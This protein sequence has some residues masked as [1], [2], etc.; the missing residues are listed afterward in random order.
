VNIDLQLAPAILEDSFEYYPDF[1]TAF[2]NWTLLDQDN[3]GTYGFTDVD[4]PG[5]GSP[6][7][8]LIFNPSQ[9]VP[10]LTDV[11]PYEGN[12][13]AACFAALTF[14]NRDWLITERITLG[15]NS[16]LRFQA[17]S[18][19][20][21][22]GLEHFKV[23]VSTMPIAIIQGFQFISGPSEIEAPA[24]WTEY[25]YDLCA[26]DELDVFIAIRCSSYDAF[27]FYVDNFAVHSQGVVPQQDPFGNPVLM[28]TSMSVVA[29]VTINMHQASAGDVLAAFVNVNGIPELRG[30]QTVQDVDGIAGC[31]LQV[32]TETNGE[33]LRF[34]VWDSSTN[35]VLNSPTT[36]NTEVNGT[37]GEWPNSFFVIY[38]S[39][40]V[41]QSIPLLSGW[42]LVSLNVSPSDH[43]LPT[44]LAPISSQIQQ[45]KGTEGI[46][47]PGNPYSTLSALTDGKAY[48]IQVNSN[49][50]CSITGTQIPFDTTLALSE[51]WNLTAYLP[52]N[53]M[54]VATAMQSISNWLQ[55]VKG[56][57]GVYI[58]GNPYSSLSTMYPGKGYWIQLTGAHDLI[59]PYG[60]AVAAELIAPKPR[61]KVTELPSSMV[62]LARCNCA[63]AGDLLIAK[64]NGQVRGAQK[65]IAPE[66]FP[67]ALLQIY[68]ETANEEISLWLLRA[69]GSEE[70][71]ANHFS[72]QPNSTLGSYPEFIILDSPTGNADENALATQLYGC[73]PNPFNPNTTISFRVAEENA[74]VS[75]NIYNLK[76][77]KVRK[78]IRA[79]YPRGEHSLIWNGTDDSGRALSS[80][81]YMIELNAG[82]YRK[83]VKALLSK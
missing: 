42:N 63:S 56:S 6:M 20:A 21:Q 62:L 3:S 12:K 44:L 76:G 27:V 81:I 66:G 14:P 29:N 7:S 80:G 34:K 45:V 58:P 68:T 10:P 74:M 50:T 72:S 15:T 70:K 55:Q 37:V 77:Q 18:H 59:Y 33:E 35:Q 17:R 61:I 67:A 82:K 30:K 78:L 1:A 4:F 24:N 16:T 13:M 19:T 75:M 22:Y 5:M 28:P 54:A 25:T 32:Y 40:G 73:Y 52:Q 64:V 48:N 53:P 57:D 49:A 60:R 31:I 8:Y 46:Y 26:Y 71:L 69:D 23:G 2:G 11:L 43:T 41:T 65:L 47:I 51:G 83:I 36:L 9:T 39:T 38:A 79:E